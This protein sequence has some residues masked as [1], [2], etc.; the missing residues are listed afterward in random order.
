M[1]S[2]T[3]GNL[4]L[5]FRDES[6]TYMR[7]HAFARRA[8]DDGIKNVARL[9][10]AVAEAETV[11]ALNHMDALGEVGKTTENLRKAVEEEEGDLF[12]LYPE[13]IKQARREDRTEAVM[14][15]TWIQQSEKAHFELFRQALNRLEQGARDIE[16]ESYFLC[17]NCGFVAVGV[18]PFSCPICRA[19]QKMFR[20]VT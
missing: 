17:T 6:E 9:F 3:D 15:M 5:G 4:R 14:S 2:K 20:E 19:P 18:A 12:T 10:R 1:E 16:E 8:E 11:H 13:F 7:Y